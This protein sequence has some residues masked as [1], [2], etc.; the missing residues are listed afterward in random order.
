M[1]Q[2][3]TEVPDPRT[4]SEH[5]MEV[6]H[7]VEADRASII[8]FSSDLWVR[9]A[10]AD[11]VPTYAISLLKRTTAR[12]SRAILTTAQ[13]Q[14]L[15]DTELALIA[16]MIANYIREL[17][18]PARAHHVAETQV[19]ADAVAVAGGLGSMDRSGRFESHGDGA[20]V[21]LATVTTDMPL[22]PL[23][24]PLRRHRRLSMPDMVR[25]RR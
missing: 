20:A 4:N 15:A 21:S 10:E 3:T 6:C 7:W 14:Q 23:T 1:N 24:G 16:C 17:G 18:F 9:G 8:R 22:V 11:N 5:L 25:A 12:G 19:V 2:V 13:L